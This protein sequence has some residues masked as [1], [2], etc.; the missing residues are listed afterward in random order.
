MHS[1]QDPLFIVLDIDGTII[2]D[3]SLQVCEWEILRRFHPKKLRQLR[4]SIIQ[5]LQSGMMRSGLADFLSLIKKEYEH[6]EFLLY[7]A[8]EEKWAQFLIPCIE[9]ACGFKF[10]R[11]IFTRKDC[12]HVSRNITKSLSKISGKVMKSYKSR[13]PTLKNTKAIVKNMIMID[14]NNLL[15]SKEVN[16]CIECPT[17]NFMYPYNVLQHVEDHV[18]Q[19]EFQTVANILAKYDMFPNTSL[20]H[21]DAL[22]Y[23]GMMSAYYVSLARMMKSKAASVKHKRDSMWFHVANDIIASMRKGVAKEV[24]VKYIN[25]RL[26]KL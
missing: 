26:S 19:K 25:Q 13:Y 8:S 10:G 22:G 18:L 5:Q 16:R 6:T 17:Y 11:P 12:V 15:C 4:Q 2:G 24:M 14:N 21:V 7:T 3:I 23:F 20:S 9:S 1:S